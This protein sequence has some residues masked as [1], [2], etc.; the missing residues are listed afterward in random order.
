MA[1]RTLH[2]KV[3][4]PDFATVTRSQTMAA[5]V[6]TAHEIYDL[7]RRLLDRAAVGDR[8]V[9]LLGV[10]GD[11]LVSTAEPRQ[12]DLEPAA[13]G[14]LEDA[15]E[16]VRLRFGDDAITPARLVEPGPEGSRRPPAAGE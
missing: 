5:P 7:A 3:R 4:F 14:E 13:W 16:R 8:P 10:G 12:L 6:G 11:S 15:V 9:R 2:L 1:A